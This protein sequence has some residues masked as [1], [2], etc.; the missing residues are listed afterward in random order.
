MSK[1]MIVSV[2]DGRSEEFELT[3]RYLQWQGLLGEIKG[4]TIA[5]L[6]RATSGKTLSSREFYVLD[7]DSNKLFGFHNVVD[8]VNA[9]G[10][11][12]LV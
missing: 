7:P 11:R 2:Y 3:K 12:R 8:D 9:R 6:L 1:Y 4:D 10:L 5:S